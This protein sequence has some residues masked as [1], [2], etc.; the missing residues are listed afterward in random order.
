MIAWTPRLAR[1]APLAAIAL[2]VLPAA[3]LAHG[4]VGDFDPN[5]PL[6]DYLWL[7][8][9]HMVMG[10]DHLLFIAG[11]VLFAGGIASASKLVSVFVLGHSITLMVATLAEW[12]IDPTRVDAI[13]A[14]S[15]VYV[16]IQGIRGK[17]TD[18][19]ITGLIV[20]AFGLVHGLGLSTRLQD[21]GLPEDGLVARILVFNVGVELGQLSALLVIVGVV[22]LVLR[23]LD[24]SPLARRAAFGALVVAGIAGALLIGLNPEE[25]AAA[26][27][28]AAQARAACTESDIAPPAPSPENHG[29]KTFYGPDETVS[30]EGLSHV[31]GHGYV[32]VR[33]RPDIPQT[34]LDRLRQLATQRSRYAIVSPDPS[35]S[36][37]IEVITARRSLACDRADIDAVVSFHDR[38]LESIGI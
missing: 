12:S 34:H 8:F 28:Q 23:L 13:I 22:T 24:D 16:G 32:I 4:L 38:W 14:L 10:W 15:L 20:F 33:Y 36:Q 18:M 26:P 17:P 37:P 25:D 6:V 2:L 1:A 9:K 35:L 19:R 3:A 21:L 11:V 7:G 27:V 5:R 30:I 29:D 31:I